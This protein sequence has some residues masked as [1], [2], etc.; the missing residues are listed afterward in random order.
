LLQEYF[1]DDYEKIRLVLGDNNK[2]EK[3]QFIRAQ[4]VDLKT[5]FGDANVDLDESVSYEINPSAFSNPDAYRS[6]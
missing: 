6:I 5:L 1:Y 3:D 2:D 4:K